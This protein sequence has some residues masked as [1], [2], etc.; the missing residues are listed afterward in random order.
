M[1]ICCQVGDLSN[2]LKRFALLLINRIIV[3]QNDLE[4]EEGIFLK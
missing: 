3:K 4:Q 1:E 2:A